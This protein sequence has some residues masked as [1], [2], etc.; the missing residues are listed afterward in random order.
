M[1]ANKM[2]EQKKM[3]INILATIKYLCSVEEFKTGN[4]IK[5][6]IIYGKNEEF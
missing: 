4:A 1:T 6:L 2:K 3:N 5:M